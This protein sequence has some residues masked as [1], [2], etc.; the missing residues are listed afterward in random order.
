M[1]RSSGST[2]KPR[3]R[4]QFCQREELCSIRLHGIGGCL[5]LWGHWSLNQSLI[6]KLLARNRPLKSLAL[7]SALLMIDRIGPLRNLNPDTYLKYCFLCHE[8]S[9]KVNVHKVIFPWRGLQTATIVH[10]PLR[11]PVAF[12]VFQFTDYFLFSSPIQLD[13]TSFAPFSFQN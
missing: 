9:K 6:P 12:S 3:I 2:W 1:Y 8:C 5:S 11:R 7:L 10:S 13:S 4:H